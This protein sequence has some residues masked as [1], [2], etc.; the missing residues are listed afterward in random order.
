MKYYLVTHNFY[1]RKVPGKIYLGR[2][3]YGYTRSK[4]LNIRILS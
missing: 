3:L 4:K 1:Y 2:I